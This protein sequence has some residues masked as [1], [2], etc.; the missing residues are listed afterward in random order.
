[1][2]FTDEIKTVSPAQYEKILK[3][4]TV[5]SEN[6]ETKNWDKIYDAHNKLNLTILLPYN[7]PL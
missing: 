7:Q 1:M 2:P 5:V 4:K 3:F 6:I